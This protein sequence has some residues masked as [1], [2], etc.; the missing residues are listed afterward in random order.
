M[1]TCLLKQLVYD[2]PDG[3]AGASSSFTPEKKQGWEEEQYCTRGLHVT[4]LI[5]TCMQLYLREAEE[6]CEVFVVGGTALNHLLFI[7]NGN[8][9]I[10][11]TT[12][13]TKTH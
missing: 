7:L 6:V 5:C 11:F 12:R 3:F 8:T 10:D 9:C 2:N 1:L 13:L 4:L